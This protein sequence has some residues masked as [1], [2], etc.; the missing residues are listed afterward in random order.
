MPETWLPSP[1][2]CPYCSGRVMVRKSA[3]G[4]IK[5]TGSCCHAKE[6]GLI[7]GELAIRFVRDAQ[8]VRIVSTG[9]SLQIQRSAV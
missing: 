1:A 2:D 4:D 6:P 7:G 8:P 9:S 3:Y 5:I